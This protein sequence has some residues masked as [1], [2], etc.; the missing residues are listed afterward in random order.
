MGEVLQ[1]RL[2]QNRFESPVVEALLNLMVASDHLR[3]KMESVCQEH[4]IT[5]GH[6]NVLRILRGSRAEGRSRCE[7]A[8]RMVERAPDVT[9]LVD[10]L[11][12]QGLVERDRSESDRRLSITR[13]TAKGLDLLEEMRPR[14][15]LLNK[16]FGARVSKKECLE[17]SRICEEIYRDDA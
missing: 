14:V 5:Q 2:Q 11:E 15:D 1:K 13:I 17:L 7:I 10:R 3:Q 16:D 12:A 9:R 6:Y 8:G 4:G